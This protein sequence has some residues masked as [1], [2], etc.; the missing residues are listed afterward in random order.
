[1]RPSLWIPVVFVVL[2]T[3]SLPPMLPFWM[4]VLGIV[5]GILFGKMVYGGYAVTGWGE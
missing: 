4:A 5:F 3:F 2:F 1:M